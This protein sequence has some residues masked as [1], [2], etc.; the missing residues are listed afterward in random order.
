M[1]TTPRK[2]GL[3]AATGAAIGAITK[4]GATP[5]GMSGTNGVILN[6][7]QSAA[8]SLSNGASA[9]GAV[10]AGALAGKATLVA[11][12]A[13][14]APAAVAIGGVAAA[15]A[16]GYGLYRGAKALFGKK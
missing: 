14:F 10:T 6:A 1:T 11:T 4:S 13:A 8:A 12:A 16:A 9:A 2:A 5:S 15:G 3:Y 7:A